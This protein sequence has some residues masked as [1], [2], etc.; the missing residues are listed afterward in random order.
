MIE[1]ITN[2]Y[3]RMQEIT[4][5]GGSLQESIKPEGFKSFEEM[6]N[7][8][9]AK[10][11]TDSS[12]TAVNST[13]KTEE[14]HP[15]LRKN[16]TESAI[17][18]NGQINSSRISKMNTKPA[19]S[20]EEL[21]KINKAI[22]TASTK[23]GVTTDLINAVIKTES[24]YDKFGISKTGAMGLMQLMPGTALDMGVQKPFDI[25]ENIDGGVKYL[26]LMLDKYQGNLD[27]AL[28]AYNAG[29]EK[30]DEADGIPNISETKNYVNNIKKILNK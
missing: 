2:I 1:N 17:S 9:K 21:D 3:K 18:N 19:L 7:Q 16:E 11:S 28:S 4:K 13:A 15:L 27:K 20:Q 23:Y 8:M 14:I 6:Y 24:D 5:M 22:E 12:V 29:P 30:V 26:K 25:D 10:T